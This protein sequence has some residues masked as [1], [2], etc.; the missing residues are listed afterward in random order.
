VHVLERVHIYVAFVS[1]LMVITLHVYDIIIGVH[2]I[3]GY[4]SHVPVTNLFTRAPLS[5]HIICIP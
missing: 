4:P 2:K 3:H 1:K 5:F